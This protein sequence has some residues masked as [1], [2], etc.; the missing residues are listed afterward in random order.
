MPKKWGLVMNEKT[1]YV[2]GRLMFPGALEMTPWLCRRKAFRML[3]R[4]SVVRGRRS[5]KFDRIMMRKGA[6]RR[7][8]LRTIKLWPRHLHKYM[9]M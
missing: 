6:R 3:K 8:N 4:K 1:K 9:P 5:S 2:A 7:N